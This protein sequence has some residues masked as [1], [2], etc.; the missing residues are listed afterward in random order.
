MVLLDVVR[1]VHDS[2]V[3]LVV[4]SSLESPIKR[5]SQEDAV[6]NDTE[7]IMHVVLGVVVSRN[8]HTCSSHP[9]TIIAFSVHLV[10]IR[11][12]SDLDSRLMS[13]NDSIGQVIVSNVKHAYL[14]GLGGFI[15]IRSYLLD[16]ALVGEE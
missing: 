1:M 14:K 15:N 4:S 10:V 8:G 2:N 12:H 3:L 9:L 5:P 11:D 7:L 13:S 6:V 16:V